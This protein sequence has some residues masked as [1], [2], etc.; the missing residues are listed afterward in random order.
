MKCFSLS[1]ISLF[2]LLFLCSESYHLVQMACF[3]CLLS[4]CIIIPQ[5]TL[6]SM[7]KSPLMYGGDVRKIDP[8]TYD[9]ITNP[10]LLEINSFSS[11]NMEACEPYI[12]FGMEG[13]IVNSEDRDLGKQMRRSSKEIKT[14]YT[15]SLGLT[16]CTESK[17]SGLASGSLNQYPERLCWKR[18][19]GNKHLAPFCVH[20]R[21]L[22]FP[23]GEVGMYQEYHHYHLVATNRIKFCLDASPKH[24]LTS[25]EFKRGTFSPCRWDSNQMW[26][27]N[28]NGTLVKSYSGLC[29]TVES[30]EDTINSGGLHSWIATGRKG[31]LLTKL[32]INLKVVLK[33]LNVHQLNWFNL[34]SS[35]G[36]SSIQSN[37]HF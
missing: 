28:P 26:E 14:T 2:I 1:S 37:E 22:Y 5:M 4:E 13:I 33:V 27:L 29:A 8:S 24:K 36:R 11:N 3:A 10:T 9:V 18:S 35:S 34:S 20:K 17:A 21:E 31:M 25:K 12:F 19:L 30:S 7:A 32:Q 6:W 23:F 15:H 16:S